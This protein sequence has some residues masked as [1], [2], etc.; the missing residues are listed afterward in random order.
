MKDEHK[1]VI[2]Y[3]CMYKFVWPNLTT[4]INLG[5]LIKFKRFCKL[6]I[7]TY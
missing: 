3:V 6:H 7:L 1:N 5:K 2:M 4:L